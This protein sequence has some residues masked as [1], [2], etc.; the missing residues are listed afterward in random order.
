MLSFLDLKKNNKKSREGLKQIKVALLADSASQ[1]I[2]QAVSG[3]G[4][5]FGLNLDIYEADY[6]QIERQVFDPSS[7]LYEA[8]PAYVIILRSTEHLLKDFYKSQDRAGFADHIIAQTEA[9]YQQLSARLSAR[10]IINTYIEIDDKVFGNYANKT[11]VSFTYQLRKINLGLMDLARQ[12]KNLFIADLASLAAHRGYEHVFD[13]KMYI[14]ADMVFNIDFVPTVAHALTQII[15]AIAGS[16]KKCLVL[17]L[18]NTTWGGIIGDD[19][20]EGIQIGYL[21]MGK[22]FTEL[23]L[24]C[25]ELKRRGIILAV[26]S[27]NTEAIAIE[28]FNS[29]PDMVLKIDDIA[30]F[31]ANWENKVD[32]IR[33]IQQVLN[34]GFDSMVFL[35]DNPFEREM[36]KSGIPDITVPELPEDPAEYVQYL[37][38]LNLFETASYTEEDA[39]RTQQYQQEAKRTQLQNSFTS[40]QDFLQSLQMLADVKSFDKFN[41]PRVSQLTQRSNQFNLRT[42]RY[43]EDD[44]AQLATSG[45][46]ITLSFNLGDKFGDHGLIAVVI[47]KALSAQELFVDSWIMSCRV[48][49]RGMEQFTLNT[50]VAAAS[51]SGFKKIVG[52]YLP[53]KKNALVKDHYLNLGFTPVNDRWELDVTAYQPKEVYITQKD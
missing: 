42:V 53:T 19:G 26:C 11:H 22:A 31:V 46:F 44:I 43:T 52:E 8:G 9:L 15:S 3:Y 13:T 36:V 12:N 20:M 37:R 41:T 7:E 18:D 28:P 35:D 49:K 17:D 38:T 2:N 45:D 25:K 27:K 34:I 48:L 40:E 16:F 23:Q 14:S 51:A 24:W 5:E 50:I 6:N 47:L 29:H 33:H 1:F 21:G 32:N 30:I 10:V 4:F 39:Q